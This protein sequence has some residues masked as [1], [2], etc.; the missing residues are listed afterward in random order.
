MDTT[1]ILKPL[2][3]ETRTIDERIKAHLEDIKKHGIVK[4]IQ[5]RKDDGTF[6]PNNLTSSF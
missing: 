4:A 2:P 5:M 1:T 3:N 6:V